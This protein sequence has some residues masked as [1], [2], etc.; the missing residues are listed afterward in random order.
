MFDT[1]VYFDTEI[2]SRDMQTFIENPQK[3]LLFQKIF[4]SANYRILE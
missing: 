3:I 4:R 2:D 1:S